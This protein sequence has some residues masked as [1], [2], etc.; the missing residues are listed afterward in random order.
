M[1][2]GRGDGERGEHG[3]GS[4]VLINDESPRITG[5]VN[6]LVPESHS[7]LQINDMKL[8]TLLLKEWQHVTEGPGL[9]YL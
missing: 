1:E 4:G 5:C 8:L 6:N 9:Y 3:R 2:L 7:E